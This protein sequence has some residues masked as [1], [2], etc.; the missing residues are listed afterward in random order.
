MEATAEVVVSTFTSRDM[1]SE[2]PLQP[3]IAGTENQV[4]FTLLL[5]MMFPKCRANALNESA[6]TRNVCAMSRQR[7]I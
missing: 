4:E 6:V 3:L 1:R 2:N 7:I 5:S